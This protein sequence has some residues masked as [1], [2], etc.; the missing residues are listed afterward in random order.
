MRELE[1]LAREVRAE[2]GEPSP[3]WLRWQ[4]RAMTSALRVRPTKPAVGRWAFTGALVAVLVVAVIWALAPVRRSATAAPVKLALTASTDG[5]RVPLADGSSLSL[6]ANTQARLTATERSTS[7]LV[8]VGKV[9]FDVVPQ[10]G[11]EFVVRA[12][13]FE[14]TVVGTRFSVSRDRAGVVEV[15]VSHGVV[16]VQV[17]GRSSPT[18]LRAG[19]QLRGDGTE[20]SLR[21]DAPPV[22]TTKGQE[23][24]PN[25]SAQSAQSSAPAID[26]QPPLEA[27]SKAATAPRDAWLRLYRERSYKAALEAAREV[28][29]DSLLESLAAQPLAELGEAARLGGDGDLA[30]R[31][32]DALDRRF[33]GSRQ[34]QDALFLSGRLL[35]SRGQLSVARRQFEAY[36]ARNDRGIY[37][38]EALGRLVEIYATSKDPRVAS[39]ARAYLERAPQGPYRRLCLS[40]LAA[41]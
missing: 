26:A 2:L 34:A 17:P 31:A 39:T 9:Q 36:L 12:G 14:V 6:S 11:R 24:P 25:A 41:P 35:A 1:R 30:L 22:A 20:V 27:P 3:H 13:S 4:Q 29:V 19:D 8:E 23:A 28:G 21:H 33:P 16:R 40:V 7:C 5:R 18:E 37:S 38:V 10:Q 15:L 32:F